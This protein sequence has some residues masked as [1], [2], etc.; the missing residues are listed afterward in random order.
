[1]NEIIKLLGSHNLL[2]TP[3]EADFANPELRPL[4]DTYFQGAGGFDARERVRLFRAAWDFVGTGLGGRNE[5][6]ERFYLA[7]AARSYQMAHVNAQREQTDS[8]LDE[9]L[10]ESASER[11]RT[12]QFSGDGPGPQRASETYG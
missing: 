5:L 7:S 8:L 11:P 4:L 10:A 2:A 3:T 1:V 9:V 12:G 6:Y